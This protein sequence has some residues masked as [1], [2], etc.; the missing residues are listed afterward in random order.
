MWAGH[1]VRI[2]EGRLPKNSKKP[3]DANRSRGVD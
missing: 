3:D 1:V 2:E